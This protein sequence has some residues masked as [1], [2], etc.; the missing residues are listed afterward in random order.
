MVAITGIGVISP[1]GIGLEQYWGNLKAGTSGIT[2]IDLFD[3][4]GTPGGIGGQCRE[5][6]D[7]SIKSTY[8]K[9]QRKSIKV[10]CREIQLGVASANLALEDSALPMDQIDHSRLGVEFGANLMLS[11]PDVLCD[12]AFASRDENNEFNVPKW[13]STGL[14]KLEPL[15]L[16][17]YLPNMPACHIGINADARGPSNSVTMDEASGNLSLSEAKSIIERG[18]ADIMIAGATGTRLNAVKSMHAGLWDQLAS[19]PTPG[20]ASKP[21]DLNRNGQVVAEGACSFIL[22]TTEHAKARGAK[23]LGY[24]LGTGASCVVDH[25]GQ[26]NFKQ[27]LIN[28][29]RAA[30]KKAKLKPEDIGSIN[31]HGLGS[32]DLDPQEAAAILEVFGSYGKEVPVTAIKS[33]IGNTG[34]ACGTVELAASIAAFADNLVPFTL[35]YKTPDPACAI[36]IVHGEPV[37]PKNKIVMKLSVTRLAQAAVSIVEGV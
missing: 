35:N 15:W 19:G 13:G 21:F 11:P 10:M 22:E 14:F 3:G 30:L 8:L 31:A 2:V 9:S 25:N 18:L 20:E 36:N 28:A 12:A 24:L 33:F 34:S 4:I 29:M 16:L 26:P 23:I 37:T 17:K 6:N 7:A 27:A 32:T 5:F 1:S